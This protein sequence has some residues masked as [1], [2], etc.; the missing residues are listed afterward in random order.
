MLIRL[1]AKQPKKSKK[2][3][4]ITIDSHENADWMRNE[5]EIALMKDVVE[6]FKKKAGKA[7]DDEDD[8]EVTKAFPNY[9]KIRTTVRMR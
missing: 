3:Q 2:L 4:T 5:S 8:E 9:R 1:K 7:S 6:Y